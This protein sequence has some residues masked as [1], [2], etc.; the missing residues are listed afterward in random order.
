MFITKLFVLQHH[1]ETCKDRDKLDSFVY[2][3][4]T[5][6]LKKFPIPSVDVT[7][8]ESWDEVKVLNILLLHIK[9]I[10]TILGCGTNI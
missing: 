8:E 10:F 4:D 2:Q 3:K 9:L 5:C 1:V 6:D 7:G